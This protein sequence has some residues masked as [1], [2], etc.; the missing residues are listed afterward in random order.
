MQWRLR[1]GAWL[2]G[3]P[4]G[5]AAGAVLVPVIA[6]M[7]RR[8]FAFSRDLAHLFLAFLLFTVFAP[9]AWQAS[10]YR[11]HRSIL[12]HLVLAAG[13]AVGLIF[14]QQTAPLGPM[15]LAA[16]GVWLVLV[17]VQAPWGVPLKL[18]WAVLPGSL[19]LAVFLPQ[20][21]EHNH[22]MAGLH[23]ITLGPILFTLATAAFAVHPPAW[24]WGVYLALVA[25][26]S[27]LLVW[28]ASP[29]WVAVASTGT[30]VAGLIIALGP[31]RREGASDL[32]Q[33]GPQTP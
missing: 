27:A 17:V 24:L 1:G 2:D 20:L 29:L 8:D 11:R 32:A 25:V 15:A 23:V 22:R 13:G 33:A 10:G 12:V 9:A 16:F 18:L 19:L 14:P 7:A 28:P 30:A 3:A 31:W 4:A 6:L 26:M 5:M 21:Q